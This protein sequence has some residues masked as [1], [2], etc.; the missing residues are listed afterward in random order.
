MNFVN[1][2]DDEQFVSVAG[3]GRYLY[4]DIKPDKGTNIEMLLI[5]E[6]FKAKSIMHVKGSVED[7]NSGQNIPAT[8]KVYN[9]NTRERIIFNQ[10]GEKGD[11]NFAL[12]EGN[13][14]DFSVEA[15]DNSYTYFSKLYDLTDLSSSS[16]DEIKIEL[17][18]SNSN[19]PINLGALTFV[20]MSAEIDDNSTYELR[21]LLRLLKDNSDRNVE[22]KVHRYDY[23]EDSVASLSDLTEVIVDT[24]WSEVERVIQLTDTIQVVQSMDSTALA[25]DST[26]VSPSDSTNLIIKIVMRDSVYMEPQ[27][28]LNYTYHNDRTSKQAESLVQYLADKG[29]LKERF[30]IVTTKTSESPPR[31]VRQEIVSIRLF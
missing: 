24:T 10:I 26:N 9:V 12:T 4:H 21:R 7:K 18:S 16:R 14:Y 29:I 20:E 23:F 27:F 2:S 17:A 25:S 30:S 19:N 8:I 28:K 1:T 22:I 6:E 5:P 3:K 13:S 15:Q 31:K 11:F